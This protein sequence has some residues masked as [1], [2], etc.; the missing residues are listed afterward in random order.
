MAVIVPV[1]ICP[2][3]AIPAIKLEIV[4][5]KAVRIE[6]KKLVEVALVKVA[7][8]EAS[9]FTFVVSTQFDPSQ[10]RAEFVTVPEATDPLP[11]VKSVTQ[12]NNPVE[13]E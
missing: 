9:N 11:P 12:V 5:V 13:A 4:A 8:P 7:F 3:V 6:V 2:T 10:Y 1:W